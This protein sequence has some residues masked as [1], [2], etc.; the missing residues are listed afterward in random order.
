MSSLRLLQAERKAQARGLQ[1]GER[2]DLMHEANAMRFSNLET[3]SSE[4]VAPYL[5]HTDGIAELR[6][7]DGSGHS[8]AHL[9]NRKNSVISGNHDVA[10]SNHSGAATEAG[11]LDQCNDW[12]RKHVESLDRLCGHPGGAQIVLRGRASDSIDPIDIG[13]GLKIASVAGDH[14]HT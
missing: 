12:D 4:R 13:A 3:F 14:G 1:V 9:G 7:Y 2:H 6:D 8:D 11:A 10:S 5:A